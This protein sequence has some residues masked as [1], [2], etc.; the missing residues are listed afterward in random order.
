VKD[1]VKKIISVVLVVLLGVGVWVLY[2]SMQPARP[3]IQDTDPLAREALELVQKH[4][5]REGYTLEESLQLFVDRMEKRGVTFNELEWQVAAQK[6]DKYVVRKII[7]E[8]G[9]VE[10]IEREFAWRVNVK[11]KSIRVI[12]L[13]AQQLMP[14]ENLPPLPH[15]E[16]ISGLSTEQVVRFG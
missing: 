10:W 1:V 16:E 11:E 15:G 4:L 6:E 9:T 8:K 13:A 14:F 5:S 2:N 3:R 12:S 7:R